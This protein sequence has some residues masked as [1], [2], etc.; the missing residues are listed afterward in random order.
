VKRVI[1]DTGPLVAF[2]DRGEPFHAWSVAQLEQVQ[3]SLVS[4]EAVIAEMDYI[5][6]SRGGDPSGLYD[7]VA[8]GTIE[9]SFSLAK[10]VRA[11]ARLLHRF[12]DQE[13]QLADACVVRLS[14]LHE[15]CVVLTTDFRDFSVYRRFERQRIPF[16]A[17]Q[18]P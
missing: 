10:E 3:G 11:V 1:V 5:I 18:L 4:C 6:R 12:A 8:D 2:M 16:L 15:D 17:P 9:V 7:R 14:E 13:M